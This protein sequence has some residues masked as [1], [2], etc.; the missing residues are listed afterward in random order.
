M[1]VKINRCTQLLPMDNGKSSDPFVEMLVAN[2][3]MITELI[4]YSTNSFIILFFWYLS[5]LL[6][7]S[8]EG[9]SKFKTTVKK[10]TLDPDFFE[11]WIFFSCFCFLFVYYYTN[12]CC[13][14]SLNL[15]MS[16][17]GVCW[18]KRLRYAFGIRTSART[19]S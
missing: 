12:F 14:R 15:L 1:F 2:K 3:R 16:I 13:F 18:Q 17:W 5:S 6:P 9:K 11:V 7:S 8:K 19:I 4:N 10:K